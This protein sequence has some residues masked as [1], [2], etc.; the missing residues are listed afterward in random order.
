MRL[1]TY[2]SGSAQRVGVVQEDRVF[3][4]DVPSMEDLLAEG[5]AG[6]ARAAQA[7]ETG[8]GEALA[9]VRLCAPVLRPRKFLGICQFPSFRRAMEAS[10][11]LVTL[12]PEAVELVDRLHRAAA[13]AA[14]ERELQ[15]GERQHARAAELQAQR[16]VCRGRLPRVRRI[17][18][19]GRK[20]VHIACSLHHR[21]PR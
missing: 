21:S 17:I 20:G 14:F 3:A 6:M 19:P 1:V 8:P 12:D 2:L 13:V 5:E 11:H 4:V 10:R 9:D 18:V 16:M 15:P 7:A